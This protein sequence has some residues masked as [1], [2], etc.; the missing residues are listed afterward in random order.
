MNIEPTNIPNSATVPDGYLLVERGIWTEEQV[1]AAAGCITRLKNVPGLS[2]RDLAM[3]ALDAAQ[4]LTPLVSKHVDPCDWTDQQVLDFLGIALRN[5]DLQGEVRLSEIRQGFELMRNR[6]ALDCKS[7]APSPSETSEVARLSGEVD[8]LRNLLALRNE[9]DLPAKLNFPTLLRKMWSGGEVQEW[10]DQQGPIYR[11]PVQ[12]RS[13]P[14]A[15]WYYFA[16]CTD[17]D[18]SC[19]FNHEDEAQTQVADHG[20]EVVRLWNV[21]PHPDAGEVE[22]LHLEIAKLQFA[23]SMHDDAAIQDDCA[24]AENRTLSAE[25]ER[26]RGLVELAES[27]ALSATVARDELCD[28]LAERDALLREIASIPGDSIN[29]HATHM[30]RIAR[31][32][33]SASAEP[34][35]GGA[36]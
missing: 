12:P 34:I 4:V 36:K 3:S 1:A 16:D 27:E 30:S 10:L 13:E 31:A 21:P 32:A 20:G 14:V 15:P 7:V 2:D 19:L 22:R 5:V 26:L 28:L 24:R 9:N 33:L 18:H 23:L 6:T 8:K 35:E 17:P 11:H 29:Y 25:V